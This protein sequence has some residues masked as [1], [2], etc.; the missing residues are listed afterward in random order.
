[1][2]R[3][4]REKAKS[5]RA[6]ILYHNYRYYVLDEPEVADAEYDQLMRFLISLEQRYP[7]LISPDSPTQRV[8]AG[9]AQGFKQVEHTL[10]MLSLAN[11]FNLD[12]LRNWY[13]RAEHLLGYS[14]F[15]MV[16]ELK[17]DG[18]AVSLI[19][20]KGRLVRGATRGD[21]SMGEDV[22]GNLKTIRSIPLVLLGQPPRILEVRG[23]VF[24][25]V[26][27]FNRLNLARA[28]RGESPFANPRNAGA[29]SLR[30]LDPKVTAS[31]NL[32]VFIYQVGFFDGALMPDNHWDALS[33]LQ[34]MGFRTNPHSVRCHT[35]EEVEDY[36]INWLGARH[37]LPYHVDGTVVK[38]N[39]FEIQRKLGTVSREPRWACAYKFPSEQAVTRLLKIGINVGRTGSLNPFAVLDPV[40]VGGVMVKMA[41]LHNEEDI[42]RKDVR[43]GDWVKV[44]RA[45]EVIPH[46]VG[47]MV[48]RR[49][50][51][52][53]PFQM[54][55]LCP[56]CATKI[57]KRL[58]EAAHFCPNPS[59]PAQF[60]E[61]LK[62]FVS[63]GAMNV[64]G[65]GERWCLI[66]IEAGLVKS[67]ADLYYIAKEE[68]L[69]LD[70]MGEKLVTRIMNN[71]DQ[72]K[73]RPLRNVIFALGILHVG[74]EVAALL[75][76]HFSSI[77]EIARASE[78]ELTGVPG[79]G[80]RIAA[81]IVSY[82]QIEENIRLIDKLRQAGVNLT[83]GDTAF[84]AREL[85]FMGARFCFTGT[86]ATLSRTQAEA[87]VRDLGGTPVSNVTGR[88][89]YL[90]VGENPGSKAE[91][92]KHLGTIR[93]NEQDFLQLLVEYGG[94]GP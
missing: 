23:E 87:M 43:V 8:G 19:Y 65:L 33:I 70:R 89:G 54:P 22:T 5:L 81:S 63:K 67:V 83:R 39:S 6:Q 66:L 35:L 80:P 72:S 45:G 4:V 68:F 29:G 77:D 73:Q 69:G 32:E 47:P 11:A 53:V 62:H 74:A 51:S 46:V 61:L 55:S 18:L 15:E 26:P 93:L 12:E 82:F 88:T 7:E 85:P 42:R 44:E 24:M 86:L 78:E 3:D 38:I 1:M 9:P 34:D 58:D 2:H 31:R 13:K 52:E 56:V 37:H 40:N 16:C 48:Y 27:E 30:Q 76:R 41:A 25:P 49:T 92:A 60:F 59:C 57:I 71:L 90:V 84:M 64:D 79:I 91:D 17:I 10:R 14:G 28:D 94:G 50:G 20:E 21:G 36:F 75:A